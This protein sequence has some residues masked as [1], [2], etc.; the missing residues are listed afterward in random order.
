MH[1]AGA[2]EPPPGRHPTTC[3]GLRGAL[4]G[5]QTRP[6][7]PRCRA[8]RP[9]RGKACA[10]LSRGSSL[11]PPLSETASRRAD[12]TE[13]SGAHLLQRDAPM[14]APRRNQEGAAQWKTPRGRLE[15][16]APPR[17]GPSM[18]RGAYPQALVQ[19]RSTL[20]GPKIRHSGKG[21]TRR[22]QEPPAIL[23]L[24]RPPTG[25]TGSAC[26]ARRGRPGGCFT[27]IV[28]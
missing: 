10:G 2:V 13:A 27:K 24:L 15:I 7:Q 14:S 3:G 28:T 26:A 6:Q 4:P 20:P 17:E 21:L 16:P 18:P 19:R 11:R 8:L 25:R 23:R 22:Q 12:L 9:R 5:A 1:T